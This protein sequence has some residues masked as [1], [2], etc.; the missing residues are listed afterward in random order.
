MVNYAGT[1]VRYA[2]PVSVSEPFR[3]RLERFEQV[4]A[5]VG[6]EI[7]GRPPRRIRHFGAFSCRS[8]RNRSYR[9]S[10]HALGNAI[11]VVGFDFGAATKLQPLNPDLPRQLRGPFQVLVAR[12]WQPAESPTARTHARFL[13]VLTDR[14][15]ERGDVFRSMIG[16]SHR[17]HSDHFHFDVSPWR[18]VDL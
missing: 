15:L 10:E 11:D 7:Y 3:S 13:R 4:V 5:D 6:Q 8:S 12:H 14:L 9:V 2:G 17:D 18:Y 1:T 16:P